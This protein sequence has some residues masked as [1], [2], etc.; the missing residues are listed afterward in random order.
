VNTFGT[1]FRLTDYGES[2]GKVIGGVLDGF[3]AGITLDYDFIQSELN[4]RIL[5][6]SPI[7]PS[8]KKKTE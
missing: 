3:P 7:P 4:R 8:E 5:Q 6:T 2:D 1:I